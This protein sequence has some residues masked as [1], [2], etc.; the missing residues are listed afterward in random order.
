MYLPAFIPFRTLNDTIQH[1]HFP[2]SFRFK[3]EDVLKLT[4]F[5]IE[6][7]LDF[8]GKGLA[9]PEWTTFV[10]PT[11]DDQVGVVFGWWKFGHDWRWC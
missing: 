9:G 11:V 8:E 3:D 1:E 10:E 2:I 4:L 5:V 6:H 7:L